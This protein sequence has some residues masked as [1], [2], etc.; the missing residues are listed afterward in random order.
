M[1]FSQ[2]LQNLGSYLDFS[3]RMATTVPGLLVALALALL[4][5]SLPDWALRPFACGAINKLQREAQEREVQL[6]EYDSKA[7]LGDSLVRLNEYLRIRESELRRRYFT[8]LNDIALCASGCDPSKVQSA[9]N[10][11]KALQD[12][13]ASDEG[14]AL[15][16]YLDT[17]AKKANSQNAPEDDRNAYA[18]VQRIE[19]LDHELGGSKLAARCSPAQSANWRQI[20]EDLLLLGV[21]G[22]A[23]GVLLDPVNKALFLQFF[24]SLALGGDAVPPEAE[25]EPST[26]RP[27]RATSSPPEIS[28][29]KRLSQYRSRMVRATASA[30]V[31]RRLHDWH[32]DRR[33]K[34]LKE[35]TAQYYIGRGLITNGEYQ[36]L[37]DAYYRFSELTTG[38][39][40]P[41]FLIGLAV[42]QYER[43]TGS[44]LLGWIWLAVGVLAGVGFARVGVRRHVEF[45]QA[46]V[47]LIEGRLERLA[48]QKKEDHPAVDLTQLQL[49]TH[50]AGKIMAWWF[51]RDDS[52]PEEPDR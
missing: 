37:I 11:Q 17:L 38:L 35:H 15:Q 30:F 7:K 52:T 41:S 51:H 36:A 32:S 1:N 43:G 4:T 44:T 22:F 26:S 19:E 40:L 5:T 25:P 47:E 27:D 10:A 12:F 2:L 21:L 24:P 42:F 16:G 49:L 13:L 9:Q 8:A 18:D 14:R 6:E 46:V 48:D 45:H 50:E 28:A 29:V 33:S 23:L 39:V 3:K 34:I 20:V 31:S